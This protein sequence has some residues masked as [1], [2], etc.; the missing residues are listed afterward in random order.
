MKV[1]VAVI[2][3]ERMNLQWASNAPGSTDHDTQLTTPRMGPYAMFLINRNLETKQDQ[4]RNLTSTIPN[5]PST[6]HTTCLTPP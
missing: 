5:H 3:Q 4:M 2:H 1:C 6:N